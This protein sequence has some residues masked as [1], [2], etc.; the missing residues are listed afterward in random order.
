MV[1]IKIADLTV[2]IDNKYPEILE[3]ARD[4]I[5]NEP[6]MFT[7]SVT[8]AEIEDE[9]KSS[10][11]KYRDGYY[12][13]LLAYKRIAEILPSYDAF[14]LHGAVI[15]V[16]GRAYSFT[17]RSGVGK[18]THIK[19]WLSEFPDSSIL[20]GDKPIIRFKDGAPYAYGNPWQ[21]KENYGK[22]I[23]APLTAVTLLNRGEKNRVE[24]I[25]IDDAL[26]PFMGQIY[27]PKKSK[28]ALQKTL[29][30]A[31]QTLESVKL[32]TLYCNM[33]KDAVYTS[34]RAIIGDV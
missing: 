32:F 10:V 26:I 15:E 27:L 4:Y 1:I 7:V 25:S 23:S 17:A 16:N 9:K 5:V 30:L 6:P 33:D 22:N 8:E 21:G 34:R 29:V 11:T 3:M 28:S 19:S 14:V 31:R 24:S 2:G 18:T 12:E 20:N 13:S